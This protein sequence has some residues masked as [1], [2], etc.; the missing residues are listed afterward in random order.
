MAAL[1]ENAIQFEDND[2]IVDAEVLAP[3]L[4]LSVAWLREAMD[5]GEICTLVERG[6]GEN[7]GQLRLTFRYAG[8]QVSIMR[9]PDGQLHETDPPPPERRAIRPSIMKLINQGHAPDS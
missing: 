9:E 3:C 7:L 6:E 8:R 2:V 5:A 4:A 1:P